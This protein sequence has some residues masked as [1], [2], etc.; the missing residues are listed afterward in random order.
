M[1]KELQRF[2]QDETG[3]GVIELLAIIAIVLVITV[4]ILKLVMDQVR[5]N[6]EC[7]LIELG[8]KGPLSPGCECS[9]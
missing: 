3:Q 2:W 8:W 5:C 9:P 4:P 1:I 6:F 7:L